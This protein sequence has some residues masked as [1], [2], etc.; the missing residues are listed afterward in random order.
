VA[1]F[2][3]GSARRQQVQVA[4]ALAIKEAQFGQLDAG[5][6]S[7]SGGAAVFYAERVD[8]DGCC[9]CLRAARVGRAHRTGAGILQPI[10][11]CL[12]GMHFVTLFNGR[13]YEVAREQ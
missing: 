4:A 3:P 10:P 12:N 2:L 8:A 1:V 7:F 13:R 5:F 11:R 9:T 6:R